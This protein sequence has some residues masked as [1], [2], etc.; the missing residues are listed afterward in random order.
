VVLQF[1]KAILAVS[2]KLCISSNTYLEKAN[3]KAKAY[4]DS[5]P[6]T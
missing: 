4:M 5:V 1:V 3:I 6:H 2:L